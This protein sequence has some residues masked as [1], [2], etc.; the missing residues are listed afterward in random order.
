MSLPQRLPIA[1]ALEKEKGSP[2][3]FPSM[4]FCLPPPTTAASV[5]PNPLIFPQ[6]FQQ[7]YASLMQQQFLN[8]LA[9]SQQQSSPAIRSSDPSPSLSDRASS[10]TQTPSI[11]SKSSLE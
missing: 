7:I 4:P 1:A 10:G 2:L 6:N 8:S 11:K 9:A 5:F 3:V